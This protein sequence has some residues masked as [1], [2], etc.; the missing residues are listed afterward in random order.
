VTDTQSKRGPRST[1]Q[2]R[3]VVSLV[4]FAKSMAGGRRSLD[5]GDHFISAKALEHLRQIKTP[6]TLARPLLGVLSA[7]GRAS[8]ALVPVPQLF[9]EFSDLRTSCENRLWVISRVNNYC[10]KR[11]L[12]PAFP[13][14]QGRA[15]TWRI[16][17]SCFRSQAVMQVVLNIQS[18]Q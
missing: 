18:V 2:E 8:V 11:P 9:L 13:L 12:F 1:C 3:Q 6:L 10:K 15:L 14:R 17:L 7:L 4:D 16:A 5:S